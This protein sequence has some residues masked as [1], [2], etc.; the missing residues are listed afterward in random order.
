MLR[1]SALYP[2]SLHKLVVSQHSSPTFSNRTPSIP[3]RIPIRLEEITPG[4][5]ILISIHSNHGIIHVQHIKRP[6]LHVGPPIRLRHLGVRADIRILADEKGDKIIPHDG[7]DGGVV[8]RRV[9]GGR[10]QERDRGA[11]HLTAGVEDELPHREVVV[12]CGGGHVVRRAGDESI[13]E[14]LL[15]LKEG[16]VVDRGGIELIQTVEEGGACVGPECGEV[17]G[18]F[19]EGGQ[20]GVGKDDAFVAFVVDEEG[21]LGEV[22]LEEF[23][24]G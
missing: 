4:L 10:V 23:E 13:A 8:A 18:L 15:C 12:A 3:N 11:V 24:V 21:H 2:V 20:A 9:D 5:C 22:A 17:D 1:I 14:D 7:G 19:G 6:I 16:G